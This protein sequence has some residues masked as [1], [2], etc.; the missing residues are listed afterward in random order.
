[1]ITWVAVPRSSRENALKSRDIIADAI[2]KGLHKLGEV[3]ADKA[4]REQRRQERKGVSDQAKPDQ[5]QNQ[6]L[7][8]PGTTLAAI[9]ANA[10]GGVGGKG[11]DGGST[12]IEGTVGQP[13]SSRPAQGRS[14]QERRK[15]ATKGP[16][17]Q[18]VKAKAKAK[19]TTKPQSKP[20]KGKT[21]VTHTGAGSG[22]RQ[23]KKAAETIPAPS[24]GKASASNTIDPSQLPT[25][26]PLHANPESHDRLLQHWMP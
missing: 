19:A 9:T 2:G 15:G 24:T 8:I 4:E 1:M 22:G 25:P 26:I 20:A 18:A 23:A 6:S 3:A 13:A 21:A 5:P 11:G 16:T 7:H 12:I 10:A 17:A 14:K